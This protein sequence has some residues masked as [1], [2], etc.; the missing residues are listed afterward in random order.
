MICTVPS[1]PLTPGTYY[2]EL[3][4]ADGF[5][6]LERVD[7]ADRLEL[8]FADV[9]GHGKLPSQRQAAILLPCEWKQ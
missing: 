8:M 1:L 7:R 6:M 5:N 2:V 3:V 4:V 9:L